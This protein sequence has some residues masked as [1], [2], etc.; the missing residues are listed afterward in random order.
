MSERQDRVAG[1]SAEGLHAGNKGADE[2][3]HS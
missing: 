1:R 3:L 2:D